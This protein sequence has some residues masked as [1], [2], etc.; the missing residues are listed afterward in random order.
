MRPSHPLIP[1]PTLGAYCAWYPMFYQTLPSHLYSGAS[2][3]WPLPDNHSDVKT[4]CII[5]D[6]I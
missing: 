2:H 1:D 4:V 6:A 3:R 5:P